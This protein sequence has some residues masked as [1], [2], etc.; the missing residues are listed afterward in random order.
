MTLSRIQN[1]AQAIQEILKFFLFL[2]C[3]ASSQTCLFLEK[4]TVPIYAIGSTY[5]SRIPSYSA[6]KPNKQI[7]AK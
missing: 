3:W 4:L 7:I 5:V 2:C 6:N 1:E